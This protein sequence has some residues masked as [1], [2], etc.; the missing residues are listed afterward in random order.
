MEDLII[1]KVKDIT[2]YK[3]NC[4]NCGWKNSLEVMAHCC[5]KCGKDLKAMVFVDN[6]GMSESSE[7]IGGID[8]EN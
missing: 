6:S 4:P 2:M 1:T 7:C 3:I 5:P 8:Y